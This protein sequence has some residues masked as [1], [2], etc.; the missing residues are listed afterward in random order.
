MKIK[1]TADSTCDLSEELLKQN[2]ITVFP[3][4]VSLGENSYLD[5]ITIKPQDIYDYYEVSKKLPKTGSRSIED[6]KDFFQKFL[7]E[8]YDAVIHYSLSSEMS[9]SYSNAVIASENIPNVYVVDT[10]SLSTG[11]GLLVMDACDMIHKGL[12]ADKIAE[13]SRKRVPFVQASFIIDKLEFLFKGGRCSQL[14]Y[15]G[16]NL[17]MIKPVIEVKDGK[18]CMARKPMGKYS[19]CIDR[20]IQDVKA[21]YTNADT[22]RCFV[23]HTFMDEGIAQHVVDTVKSW[24][25]FD[26]VLE[27]DAGSTITTH[28]GSNTIG[29]LFINDGGKK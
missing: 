24:G 28:C 8:G 27:T 18:M 14:A 10:K 22:K 12:T 19:R 15:L 2:D 1:I 3:L 29:I 21:L 17:L 25:I 20:Y 11:S 7:D 16:A 23:T 4:H 26:E 5:G 9:S 13:R 6:F